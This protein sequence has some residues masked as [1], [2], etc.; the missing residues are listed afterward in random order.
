MRLILSGFLF[1]IIIRVASCQLSSTSP[2]VDQLSRGQEIYQQERAT[3]TRH[4]E[5]GEGIRSSDGFLSWPLVGEDFQYLGYTLPS[6]QTLILE[7]AS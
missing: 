4:G 7:L 1:L 5:R 3:E 6:S 2:V